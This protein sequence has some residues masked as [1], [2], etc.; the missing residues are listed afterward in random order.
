MIVMIKIKRVYERIDVRDGERIL[1]DRLWPRGIRRGTSNIDIWI[2]N[3]GPSNELRKWFNHDP[4]KWMSF[5]KKYKKELQDNR[6]LDK[7][8]EIVI[9]ADPVTF[10]FSSRD[11]KHNNAAVLLEVVNTRLRKEGRV[12]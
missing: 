5:K 9:N 6:A 8:I 10:L 11:T 1:V 4:K 12:A 3:I 2:K 7:L